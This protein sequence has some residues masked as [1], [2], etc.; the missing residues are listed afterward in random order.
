MCVC[1]C[2]CVC[3][4][5]CVMVVPEVIVVLGS[6]LRE[7]CSDYFTGVGSGVGIGE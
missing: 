7:E 2:V 5:M 1:V 4:V 3:V 6:T